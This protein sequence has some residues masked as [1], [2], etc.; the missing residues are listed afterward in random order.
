MRLRLSK[1]TKKKLPFKDDQVPLKTK[2]N[3]EE[4]L[5]SAISFLQTQ[6]NV[7]ERTVEILEGILE[8][9]PTMKAD[10][11][12][13]VSE[14]EEKESRSKFKSMCQEL[15]W[16]ASLEFNQRSLFSQ[17]G[18]D[19]AFKL[20]KDAGPSA[21]LIKQHAAPQ[22]LQSLEEADNDLSDKIVQKC[23]QALQEMLGQT[24]A[25][26]S[27][28]QTSFKALASEPDAQKKLKFLED[29]VKT[30]V[31]EVIDGQDG[32]SVQANLMTKRVD[33]L[34]QGLQGL[35]QE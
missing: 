11:I 13:S 2:E 15:K 26:K 12:R 19:L 33:G 32:I 23:L 28:L 9:V 21:P 18:K 30:W 8:I 29:R 6:Q 10:V 16:L 22:Y 5:Q 27:D 17:E 24:D 7:L 31:S 1:K 35:I 14:E 25:T 20:F 34:V 3:L 4:H